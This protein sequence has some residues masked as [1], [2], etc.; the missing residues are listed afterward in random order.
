MPPVSETNVHTY[1][2][3]SIHF[4]CGYNTYIVLTITIL[5]FCMRFEEKVKILDGRGGILK[6]NLYICGEKIE[7]SIWQQERIVIDHT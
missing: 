6:K 3:N 4:Y 7:K 2:K 1:C 5:V